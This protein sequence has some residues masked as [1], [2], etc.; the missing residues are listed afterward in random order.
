LDEEVLVADLP[1]LAAIY[2]GILERLLLGK[3]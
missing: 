2:K 3:S 1:R